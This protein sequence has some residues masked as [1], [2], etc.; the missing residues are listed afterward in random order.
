MQRLLLMD[1]QNYDDDL[2]EILRI[3]V[4]GIIFMEEKLLFIHD[5]YGELKIPGGGKEPGED[6][7]QTL[8]REVKEETGYRVIPDS[9][10]PFGYIE[11]K[12]LSTHERAIWHQ[13][14]NIYFC[15]VEPEQGECEYSENEK[16]FGMHFQMFT[17]DEA[18]ERNRQMLMQQGEQAWNQR[19]YR[20]LLLIK[21][22]MEK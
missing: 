9:V 3:A 16:N 22:Y 21:E 12:R 17:L 4:R 5:K 10:K 13:I 6:D 14:S 15:D 19:E 8:I 18:I 1:E 11:E 7:L 20:T 2:P